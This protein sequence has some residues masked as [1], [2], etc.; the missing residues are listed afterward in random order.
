MRLAT[1]L[2]LKGGG[3]LALIALGLAACASLPSGA[4]LAN[5]T[6]AEKMMWST[7]VV[8]TRKGLATGFVVSRKDARAPG[9]R[10]PV[11]VTSAHLLETAPRGPFYL[12]LRLPGRDGDLQVAVDVEFDPRRERVVPGPHEGEWR[13]PDAR[14]V[15]EGGRP[16]PAVERAEH[17]LSGASERQVAAGVKPTRRPPTARSVAARVLVRVAEDGAFG[18]RVAQ[19]GGRLPEPVVEHFRQPPVTTSRRG[20]GC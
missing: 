4:R 17:Q 6:P 12:A 14:G 2:T 9:G 3:A 18:R 8:A 13:R 20:P 16:H 15:R 11:V 7:Y 10:V 1:R 5:L 19:G